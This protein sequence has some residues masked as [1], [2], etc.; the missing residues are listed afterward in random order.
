MSTQRPKPSQHF[1]NFFTMCMA[2]IALA[3][4]G[5]YFFGSAEARPSLALT[6]IMLIP[7]LVVIPGLIRGCY[8]T[9]V[10]AALFALFY[11][12]LVATDA[13]A[14]LHEQFL[15]LF[16]A[17]VSYT[18][19]ISAWWYRILRRRYLKPRPPSTGSV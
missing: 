2:A 13:W 7:A 16:A 5:L 4:I 9:M 18:G 8:K 3:Y 15:H 10:W 1:L 19:F 6:V 17:I 14:R 11:L 12:L